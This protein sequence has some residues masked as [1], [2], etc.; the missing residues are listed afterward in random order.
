VSEVLTIVLSTAGA[1]VG[2]YLGVQWRA[3]SVEKQELRALLDECASVLAR[4]DQ[5]R[6][7]AV[8]MYEQEGVKTS[9]RGREAINKFREELSLAEQLRD[10]LRFR[11]AEGSPVMRSYGKAL[12][13]LGR[14]SVALGTAA[15]LPE[16]SLDYGLEQ[17]G[18]MTEGEED[19]KRHRAAFLLAAQSEVGQPRR[20]L[21]R[22]PG[23]R[24]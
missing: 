14:V 5:R 17:R 1:L 2:G 18:A 13:A 23:R 19:F 8:G 10:R 3:R 4:A 16:D 22:L 7:A 15:A 9:E 11:A 6:G 20:I 12:G 21:D 24:R